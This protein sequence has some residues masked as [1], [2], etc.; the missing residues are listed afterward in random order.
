MHAESCGKAPVWKVGSLILQVEGCLHT[1]NNK[2]NKMR[3]PS[4]VVSSFCGMLRIYCHHVLKFLRNGE[5]AREVCYQFS[6][7][8]L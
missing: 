4:A 2:A 5:E 6:E 7:R 1:V 8:F 3:R